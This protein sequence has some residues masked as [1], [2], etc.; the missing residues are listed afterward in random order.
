MNFVSTTD[1]KKITKIKF[2]NT[3][4]TKCGKIIIKLE[5]IANTSFLKS[6][7]LCCKLPYF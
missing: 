2:K 3:N 1:G 6:K 4:K 5:N 7:K